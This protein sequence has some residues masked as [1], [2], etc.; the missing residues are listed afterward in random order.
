MFKS[1]G[2]SYRQVVQFQL[3]EGMFDLKGIFYSFEL[4]I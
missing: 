2:V 4:V 3:V 1:E